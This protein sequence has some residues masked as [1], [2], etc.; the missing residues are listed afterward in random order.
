MAENRELALVLKLVADQFRSELKK[1]G[2]ML[3]EFNTFV[4]DWKVQLTAAGGALFAV[5]KSTANYGEE[6]L[7]TSQKVGIN[8]EALAGLNYAAKLADLSNEQFA[9]GLKFLSQ[10]MVE[11]AKQTGD[12][13]ALFRRLGV[14]ATDATGQLRPTEAVLL[15]L[16]DVFAHAKDG[17]GKT[18]AAVKLFG[19]AGIELVPFLNQGKAGIVELMA[20]AQRLGLIVSKETAEA[21][22]KFNTELKRLSAQ[23]EG[24][25]LSIG[26]ALIPALSGALNLF[27]KLKSK[28]SEVNEENSN[29]SKNLQNLSDSFGQTRMG[30]G[31]MDTFTALGFGHRK[32]DERTPRE[33]FW[34]D[35]LGIQKPGS[36]VLAPGGS[37]ATDGGKKEIAQLADQEKLG[38]ALL[39]I[40]LA[41]N[42]AIDIE[43]KLR[44]Q[45]ADEYR[46]AIDRQLQFEKE[47]EEA[48]E[49]LGR[50]IVEQTQIEVSIRDAAR[51]RERQGLIENLKAWQ[52]YGAA[53]G[54]SNEFMLEKRLAS[55]R[56]ELAKELDTTVETAGAA[57]IAWQ[58]SD[59]E[60]IE[61]LRLRLGKTEQEMDTF[62]LRAA[63]KH[64][65]AVNQ[66]SGDF[67]EG[68][69]AG[70]RKYAQDQS[71]FGLAADM[72][73]RF[74]QTTEQGVQRFLFDAAEGRLQRLRDVSQQ[75]LGIVNQLVSQM[76]AQLL[77]KQFAG[78]FAGGFGS[79]FGPS[80]GTTE[81]IRG[82]EIRGAANPN[83]FGPGFATGGSFVVPGMGGT[84]S[85][86]VGF[87]ATPGETVD[88]RTPAQQQAN[89]GNVVINQYNYS[90]AQVENTV[91]RGPGG[92]WIIT[93]TIREVV[94]GMVQG[95]EMDS[96]FQRRFG[97]TP[98]AA[99]R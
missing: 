97:L 53:V 2:G 73:R 5:A 54:A 91:Q 82:A 17:A 21:A 7:K 77:T 76:G 36:G 87:W 20:E 32:N 61:S 66:L 34:L 9:Q 26:N 41:K 11:A 74:F 60:T 27:D 75:I 6:L 12:G 37:P 70:L 48:Q 93:Q 38:K 67:F 35:L 92:G 28:I 44:T 58:N 49:R 64:R 22:D 94:R 80:P 25:K 51:D 50:M 45:G 72:S 86:P 19:K 52:D 84:D 31:M 81:A 30:Q 56:A 1:S 29:F 3:G 95:G 65:E 88:I 96:P 13:E 57:L 79:L 89:G 14:S 83:L 63:A 4:K 8:I 16:A 40:Y 55:V 23:S 24:L 98:R 99:S 47:D 90:P 78:A 10:N 85:T 69:T 46:L 71:M 15:D 39:E 62:L 43:N 59:A 33:D 68:W 18:E 42:R